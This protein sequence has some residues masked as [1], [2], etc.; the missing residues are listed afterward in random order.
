MATLHETLVGID[1][2]LAHHHAIEY[3]SQKTYEGATEATA[4]AGAHGYATGRVTT[5]LALLLDEKGREAFI[6]LVNESGAL[7]AQAKR[8]AQA[9]E[10]ER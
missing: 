7:E 10:A 4:N 8:D 9:E 6:K 5:A 2:L 1:T 3:R